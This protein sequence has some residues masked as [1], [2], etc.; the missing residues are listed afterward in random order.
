MLAHWA[1]AYWTLAVPI[2]EAEFRCAQANG[3]DALETLFAE[4]QI[5]IADLYRRSEVE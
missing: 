3:A 4:R 1:D 2:S 5:D